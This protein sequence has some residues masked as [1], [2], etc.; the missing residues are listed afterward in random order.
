MTTASLSVV[1]LSYNRTD[2]LAGAIGSLRSALA[3]PPRLEAEIVVSD[4]ASTGEHA[5][6]L[7]QIDAD[8]VVRAPDNRGLS[9][10]HNQGLRACRFDPILSIQDDWRFVGQ[11]A[12]LEA[13]LTILRRDQTV[14]V[15]NFCPS[16][17]PLDHELRTLPDGRAYQ[18]FANDRLR[19]LRPSSRRP[20]TDRPHLKRRAFVEDLG[21]YREDLPM[22]RAELEF[23]QRVACQNRWRVAWLVGPSPFAHLGADCSFNPGSPLGRRIDMV[24]ALPVV[25][26]AVRW[27]R[28]NAK[29]ALKAAGLREGS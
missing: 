3:E 2:L 24:E 21:D 4:D 7:G 6:R 17:E 15:V 1:F 16:G 19:R 8:A 14:G 29:A 9:H 25:G 12:D 11:R 27:A 23:Q 28:S 13:A 26:G 10:N 5:E 20:Y 22:T 18:V